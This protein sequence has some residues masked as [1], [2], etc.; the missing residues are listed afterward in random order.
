MSSIADGD[1]NVQIRWHYYNANYEYYWGID[2]VQL[3]ATASPQP[4]L[5]D[6]EPDCDVD[7]YDFAVFA[8]AWLSSPGSGNWNPACDISDPN[9]SVIDELDLAV[10]TENWL[11]GVE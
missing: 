3:I 1:P 9:D 4:I 11:I 7:F 10:F 8:S 2:D 6:F 5:G